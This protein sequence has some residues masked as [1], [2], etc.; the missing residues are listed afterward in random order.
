MD[1]NDKKK[2]SKPKGIKKL[3]SGL[4]LISFNDVSQLSNSRISADEASFFKTFDLKPINSNESSLP[5][6]SYNLCPPSMSSL[7][8]QQNEESQRKSIKKLEPKFFDLHLSLEETLSF[9]QLMIM[10]KEEAWYSCNSSVV[11]KAHTCTEKISWVANAKSK[12]LRLASN[13]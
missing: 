11:F 10:K 7:S 6:P 1:A 13:G 12:K 8:E 4:D 9:F 3:G 5:K 2:K